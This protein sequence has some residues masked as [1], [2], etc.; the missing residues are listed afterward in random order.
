MKRSLRLPP[1]ITT[2][3]NQLVV[4]IQF[5]QLMFFH[6]YYGVSYSLATKFHR[7]ILYLPF[8]LAD[9]DPVSTIQL[10]DSTICILLVN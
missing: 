7:C 5:A 9:S 8:P 2:R 3:N 1:G 6:N 10:L 4:Q